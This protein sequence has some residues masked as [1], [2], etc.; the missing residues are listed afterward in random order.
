ML[1]DK[2]QKICNFPADF[3]DLSF[4][5]V[6]KVQ[7]LKYQQ[8]TCETYRLLN[9][10]GPIKKTLLVT[11][12]KHIGI[13]DAPILAYGIKILSDGHPVAT[14][15]AFYDDRFWAAEYL[16]I[17]NM[18]NILKEDDIK[19]AHNILDVA[20]LN[21][22]QLEREQLKMISSCTVVNNYTVDDSNQEKMFILYGN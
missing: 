10:R 20:T 13:Q 9:N 14:D 6:V 22:N 1:I 12:D 16:K 19:P 8:P 17:D 5:H 11:V 4:F 15:A 2:L 21:S 18:F 3:G 7:E